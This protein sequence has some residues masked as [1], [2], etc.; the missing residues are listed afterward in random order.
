[1]ID[2][3]KVTDTIYRG[4]RPTVRDIVSL[5]K[6]FNVQVVIDLENDYEHIVQEKFNCHILD[7]HYMQYP[8]SGFRSP[9]TLKL[10]TA[11]DI[12]KSIQKP[13]FIHCK[14]GQDRTGYV[15]ASYRI[16]EQ[17]WSFQQ[18]Y[19][20]CIQQG[21]RFWFY[22]WWIPSLMRVEEFT[23]IMQQKGGE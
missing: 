23:K 12:I 20:E 19:K 21:H 6:D 8:L 16:I 5:K 15:I 3:K 10:L 11:V 4:A 1:M 18:A 9:S 13:V 17:G 7:I 22:P 14:H 2:I